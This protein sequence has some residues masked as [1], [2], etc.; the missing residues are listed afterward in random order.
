MPSEVLLLSDFWLALLCHISMDV[1]VVRA[2]VSTCLCALM[3]MMYIHG[4]NDFVNHRRP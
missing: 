2:T 4:E 3:Y 1:T